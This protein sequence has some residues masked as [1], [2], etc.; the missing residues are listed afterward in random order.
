MKNI[1]ERIMSKQFSV[2]FSLKYL[3]FTVQ[4]ILKITEIV[5]D[6]TCM[7]NDKKEQKWHEIRPDTPE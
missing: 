3:N 7:F 5:Y 6:N 1:L 2:I 4:I